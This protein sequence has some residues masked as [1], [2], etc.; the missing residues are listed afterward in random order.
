ML[1]KIFFALCVAAEFVTVPLFLKN[2]WPKKTNASLIFKMVSSTLFIL[3]GILAMKIAN[4]SSDYAKLI[5]WGLVMGWIGDFFLHLKTDKVA[6]FGAGL[7]AFLAGHIFYIIAFQ[8]A[9]KIYYPN[10]K[11]VTWYEVLAV[12]VIVGLIILY[13]VLKKIKAK[14]VM[15]APVVLYAI[16]ISYMLVKAA[17]LCVAFW[18]YGLFDHMILLCLT[19]ALGALLFVLSDGS[20]GLILFA[21]KNNNQKLKWFNIGTYYAAQVLL[22]SSIFLIYTVSY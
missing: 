7:F 2:S 4:N 15:I 12:V 10:A 16:T 11:A 14:P 21:G 22:A 9:I 13:A 18:G 1:F 19:V 17:R 3:C 5:I 8:K 20:L 6:I